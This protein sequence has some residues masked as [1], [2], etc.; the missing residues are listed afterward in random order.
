MP[1]RVQTP[2]QLWRGARGGHARETVF[3][4]LVWVGIPEV[5]TALPAEGTAG[6]ST[7][8][9]PRATPVSG[10]ELLGDRPSGIRRDGREGVRADAH[11][12]GVLFGIAL[13]LPHDLGHEH[14]R[15]G[16]DAAPGWCR[17][18][19]LPV[20]YL[21]TDCPERLRKHGFG[22]SQFERFGPFGPGRDDPYRQPMTNPISLSDPAGVTRPSEQLDL[23]PADGSVA[24]SSGMRREHA[25]AS[26]S[27]GWDPL[28]ASL[29]AGEPDDPVVSVCREVDG[30]LELEATA[31]G[32]PPG[33]LEYLLSHIRRLASET[34]GCCGAR[35]ATRYQIRAGEPARTVCA[36]CRTVLAGGTP[37]LVLA[38]AYWMLDGSRRVRPLP[39]VAAG[40][41]S[42]GNSTA[43]ESPRT[44]D[45]P[46]P[47]DELRRV[48]TDI[49][50]QMSREIVGQA[51]AVAA[52]ALLGGLHVGAALPRGG[53]AL[54][55]GPSGVGKSSL[56]YAL[57]RA[58]EPWAP[59]WCMV[60]ALNLT[61]PGWSGA[62][63]I[64]DV[65]D[66]ALGTES[67]ESPRARRA[68]VVIDELH[69]ARILPGTHG[70][71][72]AKRDEC[73]HSL[74]GLAGHGTVL[75]GEGTREWSAGAAL[76]I[77]CGAFTGLDLTRPLTV[78]RLHDWGI[79]LEL[80][81]RLAEEII[82]LRRL[83]ERDLI[84]LLRRWPG[85]LALI[86]TCTRLG[87]P[88]QIPEATYARAARIVRLGYDGSTPRTAGGWLVSGLRAALITALAE[89]DPRELVITPD[90]LP[91]PATAARRPP[92]DD[93]PP[94]SPGGWDTTI[95]LTPR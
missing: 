66:A 65:I 71:M 78:Q 29:W 25:R 46:L 5:P 89:P 39:I 84:D 93:P 15:Y 77:G 94:E 80:G 24:G 18:P 57:R 32:E 20:A 11:G 31:P 17:C 16:F 58:L 47:P 68:V 62:P 63:S 13:R 7:A 28:V 1:N 69:H 33:S 12:A 88:V 81:S 74:L 87:Y 86:E 56:A 30:Q 42:G 54:I 27:P 60:D 85:L 92:S 49:R 2:P 35:H 64:G 61:S 50:D 4:R 43:P 59:V 14:L 67:P 45:E 40:S 70:T 38:D 76:V 9:A 52:L 26:V 37:Y 44:L 73:L 90:S 10:A 22:A 53:R 51:D 36:R 41:R 83:R 55:V 91:I 6:Q 95:I 8:V 79:P 75:L 3:G 48:I 21:A 23:F 19:T 72:A 82:V 34:C